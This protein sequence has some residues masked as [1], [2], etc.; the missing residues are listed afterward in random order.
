M[1]DKEYF[2]RRKIESLH[3]ALADQILSFFGDCKSFFDYGCGEG[4][5]LHALLSA[6]DSLKIKGYEPFCKEFYGNA[7]GKVFN[8]VP[9]FETFDVVI[10]YDVLEHV[11]DEEADRII[12][13]LIRLSNKFI[14]VSI[15]CAEVWNRYV[16]DTH[17]NFKTM[18]EWSWKFKK[19]GC[20]ALTLPDNFMFKEQTMVFMK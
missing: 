6:D 19:K 2:G 16:D 18:G 1:F 10:C 8:T 12:D 14:F 11:T 17:V 13:E 3:F 4:F 9:E 7:I 15:C 20:L 5:L